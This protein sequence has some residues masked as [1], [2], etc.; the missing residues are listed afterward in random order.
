MKKILLT[1]L[2]VVVA[3]GLITLMV[4]KQQSGY[5]KVFTS[6]IARQSLSTVVNGTGQIKPQAYVNV[7]AMVMGRI[8]RFYVKEGDKVK[9]G[10]VVAEIENIQQEAAVNGQKAAIV[11]AQAN[12]ASYVAAEK[13]AQANLE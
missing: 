2:G 4:V 12:I 11:A 5:T 8:T 13:T 3:A 9:K 6:R 7:G 1:V 10:E